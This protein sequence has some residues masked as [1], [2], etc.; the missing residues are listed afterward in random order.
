ML[1]AAEVLEVAAPEVPVSGILPAAEV[2]ELAL[3]AADI[4]EV[5]APE[6]PAPGAWARAALREAATAAA[7]ALLPGDAKTAPPMREA[8]E[9]GLRPLDAPG[10]VRCKVGEP[11]LVRG[12]GL[13]S[14]KTRCPS[15][16][17]AAGLMSTTSTRS[18]NLRFRSRTRTS[19]SSSVF[20]FLRLLKRRTGNW[21]EA[22]RETPR[23]CGEAPVRLT[24][25]EL[26]TAP[27]SSVPRSALPTS[28]LLSEGRLNW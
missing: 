15:S 11:L 13:P 20:D 25:P 26:G 27:E 22:A 5:A 9:L 1:P 3:P 21:R 24:V 12:L 10:A 16:L 2:L 19:R 23:P 8:C 18:E 14:T 6:V 17:S 7:A 28:A 4:L